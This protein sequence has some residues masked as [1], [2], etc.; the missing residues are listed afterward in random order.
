MTATLWS[1]ASTSTSSAGVGRSCTFTAPRSSIRSSRCN[2]LA[3][4][5]AASALLLPSSFRGE[6][7]GRLS[8]AGLADRAG[9]RSASGHRQDVEDA[10]AAAAGLTAIDVERVLA[11]RLRR[12]STQLVGGDGDDPI[13]SQPQAEL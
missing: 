1:K 2:L 9:P 5:S 10:A 3:P 8:S 12:R 7:A 13:A 11:H 6:L 4:A